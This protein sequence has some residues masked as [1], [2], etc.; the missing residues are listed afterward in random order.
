MEWTN[1]LLGDGNKDIKSENKER[2]PDP[3]SRFEVGQGI[4]CQISRISDE[5]DLGSALFFLSRNLLEAYARRNALSF[6]KSRKLDS[7]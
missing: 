4:K 1:D 7:P 2:S 6:E 5:V 3:K